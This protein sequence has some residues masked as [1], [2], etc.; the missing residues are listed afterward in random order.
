M[1]LGMVTRDELLLRVERMKA[2]CA[3]SDDPQEREIILRLICALLE[4]A[5]AA[6]PDFRGAAASGSC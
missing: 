3:A 6:Y 1:I 5:E 2:R 4:L